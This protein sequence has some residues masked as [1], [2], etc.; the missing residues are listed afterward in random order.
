MCVS[1]GISK[2]VMELSKGSQRYFKRRRGNPSGTNRERGI[3]NYGVL[4]GRG[5]QVQEEV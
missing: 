1:F 3:M 2:E 4:T 5:G